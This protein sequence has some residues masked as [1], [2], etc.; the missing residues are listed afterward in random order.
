MLVICLL[1]HLSRL[2]IELKK[3]SSFFITI[4][5]LDCEV[6]AGFVRARGEISRLYSTLTTLPTSNRTLPFPR[7]KQI[8]REGKVTH[9][10]S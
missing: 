2:F 9:R 10:Q 5:Y 8:G 7:R 4:Q 1:P 3:S 6:G